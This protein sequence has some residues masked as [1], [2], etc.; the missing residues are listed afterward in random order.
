[1]GYAI[2]QEAIAR[3]AHVILVSGPVHLT[4]PEG[5]QIINVQT[6]CQMETAV[7][8]HVLQ[9]DIIICTAAV[10]DM[11][12]KYVYDFKLK[13]N[14]NSDSLR[15]IEFVENPDILKEIGELKQQNHILIG[16]AAETDNLLL[17]AQTKLAAKHADMIV[18]N[19]VSSGQVFGSDANKATFITPE[20]LID[21]PEMSKAELAGRIFDY[22]CQSA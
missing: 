11:R 12:P 8:E 13:K 7:I 15:T 16:F 22:I 1:M 14:A 19:D 2:A 10:C 4:V 3:G 18:A 17:N 9:S 21:I 5:C 6:A 20:G